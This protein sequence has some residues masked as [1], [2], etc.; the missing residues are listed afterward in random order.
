MEV[1]ILKQGPYLIATI[2]S[3]LT[4]KD[5]VQLRDALVE[6]VGKFRARGVIIDLT[7]LDVM[8]SFATGMLQD[9]AHM[10]RLRGAETVIVGIQPDVAFAMVHMGLTL[11]GVTTAL[12]LE[13]GLAHFECAGVPGRGG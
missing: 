5:I 4:D 7:A 10:V 6:Q 8:D 9:M 2:Q 3:A 11:E 1:P 12:D 13:E